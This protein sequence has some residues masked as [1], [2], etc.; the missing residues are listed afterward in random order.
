MI[1]FD[2]AEV[3]DTAGRAFY[4]TLVAKHLEDVEPWDELSLESRNDY[5][6]KG[7]AI[8]DPVLPLIRAGEQ[9]SDGAD[10]GGSMLTV[11]GKP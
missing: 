4:E 9:P 1:H 7:M 3:R 10:Q 11:A 2:P 8:V 6:E 5:S